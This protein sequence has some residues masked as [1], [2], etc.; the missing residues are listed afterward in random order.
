[1]AHLAQVAR[2]IRIGLKLLAAATLAVVLIF[3]FL[4]GGEIAK[5]FFFPTPPSPPEEKFGRL[6]EVLF[7]AQNPQV[8]EYRINTLTG[9]LPV[10]DACRVFEGREYCQMKVYRVKK[11]EP[12][13][14]ALKS[15]RERLASIGYTENETKISEQEYQWTNSEGQ[16]IRINIIT[17]NFRIF[18]N[19]LSGETPPVRPRN[20]KDDS[21]ELVTRLIESL[22]LETE[23]L[24]KDS[25]VL[26]YLKLENGVLTKTQRLSEAVFVRL[27]LFQKDI[28]KY[29]IYYP[30]LTESL[31]YFIIRDGNRLTSI[32]NGSF[33]HIIPDLS[34]SSTYRIKTAQEAF[35]DLKQG[36]AY[37][38][39]DDKNAKTIDITDVSLGYYIGDENQEYFLPI[40]VFRGKGFTAYV[41]AVVQ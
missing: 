34:V 1:M 26:T 38:F 18:S 19:F 10:F 13:L 2:E 15:A 25:S 39:L 14:V 3:A 8:L 29:K 9:Y 12:S 5:N 11:K 28:D 41:Q 7:P 17:G 36:N 32:V 24:N 33:F 21:Y 35:E 20:I 4:R 31:M 22:G 37:V 16:T 6:P 23:D 40:V 27:D 30:G